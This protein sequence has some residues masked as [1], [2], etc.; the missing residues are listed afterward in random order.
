MPLELRGIQSPFFHA[1]IMENVVKKIVG[2]VLEGS[3]FFLVDLKISKGKINVFVDGDA[4]ISIHH[5]GKLNNEIGEKL[6]KEDIFEHSYTLEVSSP[7]VH[8]PIKLKRQYK[9]NVNRKLKVTLKEEE[10]YTG[11]LVYMDADQIVL[12]DKKKLSVFKFNELK[13]GKVII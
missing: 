7:G 13:E 9:K 1:V 8:Q 10:N 5:C 6:D 4:G 2:E 12:R 3:P 11:L